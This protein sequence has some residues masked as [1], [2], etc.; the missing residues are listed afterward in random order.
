MFHNRSIYDYHFLIKEL[1]DEFQFTYLGENTEKYIIFTIPIEKEVT[2]IDKNGEIIKNM[3]YILQFIDSAGFMSS[4]ISNLVD[5]LSEGIHG[6][7]C[8]YGHN[9]KKIRDLWN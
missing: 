2:R 3:S 7:K 1:A 6:I 4:S 8:E 5:N 9:D